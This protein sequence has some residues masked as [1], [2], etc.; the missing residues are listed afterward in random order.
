M[1]ILKKTKKLL[2]LAFV[3]VVV[4]QISAM[5]NTDSGPDSDLQKA[6]KESY[7]YEAK[8]QYSDAINVLKN[9]YAENVYEI[10]LRLG[11]LYYL[12]KQH[13]ES[14]SYYRKSIDLMPYCIEAKF[15][16]VNP[17]AVQEK[18][19]KVYEQYDAILVIDPQNTLANY[20]LGLGYYYKADY[21]NAYKQFEKVVKLYPFDYS[22][23][24]MFA[25]SNYMLGKNKEAELLFNKVLLM[26]PDDKSALEGLG[27]LGK[28]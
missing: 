24:L 16:I 6:F 17:L 27:L 3:I 20:R 25:W 21:T 12:N 13:D 15:G 4:S 7:E 10:N 5:S 9:V 22:S 18:W 23:V 8:G 11:W 14:V 19:D 2:L 26:S 28:K 1:D